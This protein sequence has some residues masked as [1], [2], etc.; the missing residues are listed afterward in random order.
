V[1]A[2][3]PKTLEERT[4][5]LPGEVERRV[6][7]RWEAAGVFHP[8]PAGDAAENYSIAIPPPNVTGALHMGHALNATIQDVLVRMRRMQGKR[9]KWVFGTDHA[10]IATQVKV[11][12]QLREEGTSRQE[13]GR[14]AFIERVWR[15]RELY[16]STIVEQFKR[17]GVSADY[18]DERFTMDEGY[19]RAVAHVFVKLFDKGL[20]YR[21]NYMVNWDPGTRSAIS[22]LEVEQRS[23][24]DTLFMVDYPLESGSGA[25]TVATVRPETMLADTAIAVHPDDARYTRLVGEH[26]ILPLVGRRL[27]IIADAYVDPAFGTGALKITPGHDAN[28]FEIGRAHRLEEVTV[29]GEDGR[30]TAAA[31]ERFAGMA[32][33]E[34]RDAVVAALREQRL[35]SGTRPY[36]H[37]VPHS[38]RSGW[39]IE[40][41]IS[42]QWFCNM[43]A[44]APPAIACVADGR[45]RFH[46][47]KPWTG[48]YLDWLA[49]IRPW[50]IS[51]Q[52]WWGHRLPVWYCDECEETYV[53]VSA[54]DRS[55]CCEAPLRQDDDVLDTWFSSALWPFATLGWPDETPALQ[56][57]YPTDA[58]VTAR[59][60]IFLWVARMVMM[61]VEFTGSAPFSDV[62]INSVIQAP[63]GRRMSKSLGTGVDPLEEIDRYGAD[64]LRFGLL[65][66]ASSQ[67]VR[68]SAEKV[69]QGQDLA[70][71]LWNAA[72]LVMLGQPPL[73][74][75]NRPQAWAR[76]ATHAGAVGDAG[77]AR[78]A[79]AVAAGGQDD[80][81]WGAAAAVEDRWIVSR[82]E[83]FSE[84]MTGLLESYDFAHAALELYGV[85]WSEVC[86][87]YLE[88]V[89][90]RLA[91]ESAGR[92][93]AAATL[94]HVLERVLT[95]LHP[96]MPFVT[97]ELWSFLPGADGAGQRGL[98]AAEP[99]P[100]PAGELI[101][102]DAEH[103]VRDAITAITALRRYRD[104]AG[105]PATAVLPARLLADGY[106]KTSAQIARLARCELVAAAENGDIQ[107]TVA[108]PGGTVQLLRSAAIDS[109]GAAKRQAARR[110]ALEAEIARAEGRLA[111]EG[112][113]SKAPDAVVEAEREKLAGFRSE[114]RRLA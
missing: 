38:H 31:G 50:C 20:I 90:P 92:A 69:K 7:E 34:A 27:P 44:L 10:G 60:I 78:D 85:F 13:L 97:E 48:V 11:E 29:I 37:D 5:Y 58:L 8:E 114:L 75:S 43:E 109:A 102:L 35:L 24:E 39:R 82:L 113:V 77:A 22:D 88:L 110:R 80:D 64:A 89:K 23:V 14:D 4:R 17:L 84:R 95:L 103:V 33:D 57:F 52:L 87:W 45:V 53:S 59:D 49:K 108:V 56:A 41:L 6:F 74:A 66:M 19:A 51:R 86:D 71:K 107:A 18:A 16:G 9:T 40:P 111:N 65:A 94:M 70:N 25:I 93:A 76:P 47:E 15:W 3:R 46:P 81:P 105:V 99:W 83:S 104:D 91:G 36:R 101:D 96:I 30:M 67:D 61:G 73:P 55:G 1:T 98:L 2:G 112:F 62:A 28:D 21:D 72:R 54:P 63:D 26:A 68:Y 106:T 42:L 100:T 12:Q 32:I 79:G